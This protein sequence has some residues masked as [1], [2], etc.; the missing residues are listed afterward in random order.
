MSEKEIARLEQRKFSTGKQSFVLHEDGTLSVTLSKG[1]N[2]QNFSMPLA[3]W[4]PAPLHEKDNA[5]S[6]RVAF[7]ITSVLLFIVVALVVRFFDSAESLNLAAGVS[8]ILVLPIFWV[9]FLV[10]C[11]RK[12]YDILVFR[13]PATQQTL[14]LHN[15]VPNEKEFSS[16]VETLKA[17]VKKFQYVPFAQ[18]DTTVAELREFARL[19]DDGIL[20]NE[21]FEDAK[22]KLLANVN[23][24]SKIGFH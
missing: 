15:N 23:S 14:V 17:T 1:G 9:L 24:P 22:R 6:S 10:Q 19:R 16:F 2:R 11:F 4:D 20:T 7:G 8:F 5:M 21:E 18:T 3:G 13:N 12:R